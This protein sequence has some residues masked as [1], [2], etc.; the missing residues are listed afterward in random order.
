MSRYRLY[1]VDRAG[2]IVSAERL[3][4]DSDEEAVRL[5]QARYKD[6]SCE[7]WKRTTLVAAVP[8]MPHAQPISAS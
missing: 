7:L 5:V 3:D 4:A 1:F 6:S 2:K 8:T